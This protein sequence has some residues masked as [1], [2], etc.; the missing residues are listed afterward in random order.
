MRLRSLCLVALALGSTAAC[1]RADERPARETVVGVV[2]AVDSPA[3]NEV[4]SFELRDG[5]RVLEIAIDPTIT[6]SFPVGH[7]QTHRVTSEPVRV[8]VE[9]RGRRLYAVEIED[10]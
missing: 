4:R 8:E 1:A 3:L 2:V 5:D 6:Y 7:L 9:R 10:A